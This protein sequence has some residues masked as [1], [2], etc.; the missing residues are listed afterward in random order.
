IVFASDYDGNERHDL[1]RVPAAG[2]QVEQLTRTRLSE[3]EP[4]FSPDGKRLAFTA[5]PQQEFLFQLH[6]MDLKTRKVTQLTREKIK[7][8]NLRWSLDGK[9]IAVTRTGDEQKGQLL[10][11]DAASGATRVVEPAEKDGILLAERFS[12]NGKSLLLTARNKTGFLQLAVLDLK[13]TE[14]GKPPR[15]AGPLT[16]IGP[17]DWDVLGARWNKDGIYFLRNEG[18]ATGLYFLSSPQARLQQLL[19]PAGSISQLSLDD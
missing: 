15:P 9:T 7:V 16:L 10:L 18:G 2:G 11:V 6:V 8:Q 14:T 13:E 19:P 5:D 4:A 1:Y 12:P 17:G 3:S